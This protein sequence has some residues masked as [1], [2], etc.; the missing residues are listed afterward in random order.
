MV[1]RPQ[2]KLPDILPARDGHGGRFVYHGIR[3]GLLVVLAVLTYLLFP[4]APAVDS[5]IFEV[6]SVAT[7]NVI[8]PF[9]FTVKKT[10]AELLRERDELSRSVKPLFNFRQAALDSAEQGLRTF[11]D[12]LA[13]TAKEP[14]HACPAH[15]RRAIRPV[16]RRR[17]HTAGSGLSLVYRTPARHGGRTPSCH[18][19]LAGGRRR[20]ERRDR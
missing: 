2:L 5:P 3:I 12:S 1:P 6:G 14:G 20:R 11:M 9:A 7:D 16:T 17:A 10:D 19:A 18:G 13:A 4:S 15:R 8:A